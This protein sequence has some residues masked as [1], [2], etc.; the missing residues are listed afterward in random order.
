MQIS[1]LIH[2]GYGIGGT[3][4]TI[5]NPARTLAQQ[6]DVEIVS[7]CRHRDEPALEPGPGVR[8]RHLVDLREESPGYDGEDPR[9]RRPARVFPRAEARYRQY[10]ALT[11]RRIAD[12]LAGEAL[13]HR[14][15]AAALA[16]SARFDPARIA[17]R[18]E[19]L[20]RGLLAARTARGPRPRRPGTAGSLFAAP[21]RG[22][23]A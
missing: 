20:Y 17:E 22:R 13:R 5:R 2:N 14:M 19:S 1:F 11:D 3:I 16:G 12:H 18:H 6:H 9:H 21:T 7:V 4:R 8:L 10:S 15:A 23:T